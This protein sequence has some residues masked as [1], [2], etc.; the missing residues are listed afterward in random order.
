MAKNRHMS[1]LFAWAV[2]SSGGQR[3]QARL[4]HFEHIGNECNALKSNAA[5]TEA[6][7]CIWSTQIH[8]F[9]IEY[10]F[11]CE[12]W[13]SV[14]PCRDSEVAAASFWR[15]RQ[16]DPQRPACPFCR[17]AQ[18]PKN[19]G[20][21]TGQKKNVSEFKHLPQTG[22]RWSQLST[23]GIWVFRFQYIQTTEVCV[24]K[25]R[26]YH[27]CS[28]PVNCRANRWKIAWGHKKRYDTEKVLP[29]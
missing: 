7:K 27:S 2:L 19:A 16:S 1:D 3:Y 23:H 8:L 13:I 6:P 5:V 11:V 29:K 4:D 18:S 24:N 28:W 15:D 21:K 26:A 25:R 22:Q 9:G 10:K 17:R 20:L 14:S 12:S